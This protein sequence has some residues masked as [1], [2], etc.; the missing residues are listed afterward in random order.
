MILFDTNIINDLASS[1]RLKMDV[2]KFV[3]K[4]NGVFCISLLSI[5][6]I[7]DGDREDRVSARLFRLHEIWE[8]LGPE[9]F[10]IFIGSRELIPIEAR[11]RGRKHFL[12]RLPQEFLD[13]AHKLFKGEVGQKKFTDPIVD[14]MK[15]EREAKE[16]FYKID[17]I[18]RKR[19]EADKDA[20]QSEIESMI[21]N[22]QGL[23]N[24]PEDFEIPAAVFKQID[25]SLTKWRLREIRN[26]KHG[27]VLIKAMMNMLVF[28]NLCNALSSSNSNPKLSAVKKISEGQWYDIAIA[29]TAS[30]CEY[31]ITNDNSL[32]AFCE[33]LRERGVL[34]F[35]T[36]SIREFLDLPQFGN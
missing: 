19:V 9:R 33:F 14:L 32:R 15:R 24:Y 13:E 8:E 30:Y 31:F 10:H 27:Y 16:E 34:R 2:I 1:N 17:Q 22:F 6:E 26:K 29:A 35:K 5:A 21:L 4:S 18:Y 7:L 25:S 3:Q 20:D 12:H 36:L 11:S 28:R 23:T